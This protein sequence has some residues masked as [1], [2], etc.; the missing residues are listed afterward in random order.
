MPVLIGPIAGDPKGLC[1]V[2]LQIRAGAVLP[3]PPP[4][5]TR[6]DLLK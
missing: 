1:D 5:N 3:N 2:I 6:A 4:G